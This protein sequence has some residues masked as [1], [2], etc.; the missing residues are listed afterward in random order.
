M[1]CDLPALS[2]AE[3]RALLRRREVSPRE[4]LEA[5]RARIAEVEPAID[6]Y[7]V[8]RFRTKRFKQAERADVNLPLGGVP[9]AI[10]DIISVAGQPCTCASQDAAELSGALRRDR[11]SQAE[12]G[13]RD[14]IWK[15]EHGRVRDGRFHGKLER[16]TDAK[17]LGHLAGARAVPVAD[18]PRRWRRMQHLARSEQTRADRSASPRRSPA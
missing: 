10:K 3:L 17:S 8:D 18:R 9:I 12:S 15:N 14:S 13:G 11:H 2:I 4:V 16:E 5:L 7:L 6:A 1:A